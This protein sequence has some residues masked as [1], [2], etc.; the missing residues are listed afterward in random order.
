[1]VHTYRRR[2]VLPG[3]GFEA[4]GWGPESGPGLQRGTRQAKVHLV[5][6]AERQ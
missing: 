4:G 1:M 3:G 5:S 2:V 6:E